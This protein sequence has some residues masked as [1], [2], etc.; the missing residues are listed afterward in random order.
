MNVMKKWV[1][2]IVLVLVVGCQP[3]TPVQKE[4]FVPDFRTGS[5]ALILTFVPNLPPSRLFD[6]EEFQAVLD[7]QNIGAA[8]LGGPGDR[9]YLTGF[10]PNIITG[11]STAGA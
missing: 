4:G 2:L 6:S 10:D 9:V 8:P 11:V 3:G 7:I 5:Q 1:L